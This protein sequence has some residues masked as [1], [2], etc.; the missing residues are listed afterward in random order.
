MGYWQRKA[1]AHY[2]NRAHDGY[3]NTTYAGMAGRKRWRLMERES[4]RRPSPYYF[5]GFLSVQE[6]IDLGWLEA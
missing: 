4:N 3:D 2:L 1:R 5:R 6:Q